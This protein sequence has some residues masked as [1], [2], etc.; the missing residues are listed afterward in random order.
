M[1]FFV[2]SLIRIIVSLTLTV[3]SALPAE[4]A[5]PKRN[6]EF[7]FARTYPGFLELRSVRRAFQSLA[8]APRALLND[9]HE[10]IQVQ[11]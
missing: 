11:P 3:F 4:A 1:M 7:S 5:A 2:S 9:I 6:G 8:L 10:R